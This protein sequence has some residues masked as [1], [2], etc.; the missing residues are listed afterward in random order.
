[1]RLL[2]ALK[3]SVWLIAFLMLPILSMSQN[4]G[5][6]FVAQTADMQPGAN[7][8]QFEPVI[9][10]PLVNQGLVSNSGAGT[11]SNT[12]ASQVA[13]NPTALASSY[14]GDVL[15][16]LSAGF[17][18]TSVFACG[19]ADG[20]LESCS[21]VNVATDGSYLENLVVSNNSLFLFDGTS[22]IHVCQI[23]DELGVD[24]QTVTI[25]CT[26]ETTNISSVDGMA[27]NR[28]KATYYLYDS[29]N[30]AIFFCEFE[31]GGYPSCRL[32]GSIESEENDSDSYFL[33]GLAVTENVAFVA[34]SGSIWSCDIET[35]TG[36]F[37]DCRAIEN[38][39]IVNPQ[40]IILSSDGKKLYIPNGV[41][42]NVVV[43]NVSEMGSLEY[44]TASQRMSVAGAIALSS[45]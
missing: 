22:S 17:S 12:A 38:E 26:K 25:P 30:A 33:T 20:E 11:C 10:C 37:E 8:S 34:T 28:N 24:A 40:K 27:T 5:F 2:T 16:I 14:D 44:C 41:G 9:S 43:C 18:D 42:L 1:M 4:E 36:A 15:Y 7:G 13:G 31:E 23:D 32:A 6:A 21:K 45:P 3:R 39:E 29:S 35:M 19:I